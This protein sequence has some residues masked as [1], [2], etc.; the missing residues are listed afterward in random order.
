MSTSLL[1][2]CTADEE[3]LGGNVTPVEQLPSVDQT[4]EKSSNPTSRETEYGS[5]HQGGVPFDIKYAA[6]KSK[7]KLD[8]SDLQ[9][10]RDDPVNSDEV[11]GVAAFK[12]MQELNNWA[13]KD[14]ED[15][16][17]VQDSEEMQGTEFGGGSIHL[18]A[19]DTDPKRT[20]T[21]DVPQPTDSQAPIPNNPSEHQ[22]MQEVAPEVTQESSLGLSDEFAAQQQVSFG[23]CFLCSSYF[24]SCPD[25]MHTKLKK[26]IATCTCR[27]RML[28]NLLLR[29]SL[30]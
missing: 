19:E 7:I 13:C 28:K 2:E 27:G 1:E 23:S 11:V 22:I 24:F 18:S 4:N 15:N 12:M 16:L 9:R 29:R 20:D 6:L 5:N 21:L 14:D 17:D 25:S 26:I 3:H 8:W 30:I 10:M